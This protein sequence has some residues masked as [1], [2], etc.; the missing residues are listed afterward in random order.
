MAITGS[1][2]PLLQGERGHHPFSPLGTRNPCVSFP[3]KGLPSPKVTQKSMVWLQPVTASRGRVRVCMR[4]CVCRRACVCTCICG[5]VHMRAYVCRHALCA[6]VRVCMCVYMCVCA[7]AFV[8][9]YIPCSYVHA[10]VCAQGVCDC[11]HVHACPMPKHPKP[12]LG[13]KET[14]P[15]TRAVPLTH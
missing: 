8:H 6:R 3:V 12:P 13:I 9:M 10:G 15:L 2:S 1:P 11:A 14:C 4:A 5:R 7:H